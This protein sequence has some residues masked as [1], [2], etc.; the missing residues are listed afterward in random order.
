MAWPSVRCTCRSEHAVAWCSTLTVTAAAAAA[1][2]AVAACVTVPWA[3]LVPVQCLQLFHAGLVQVLCV[4]AYIAFNDQTMLSSSCHCHVGVPLQARQLSMKAS[5]AE[6]N[7]T[8]ADILV[9]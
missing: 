8:D 6:L 9:R 3:V 2:A 7:L 5:L 4:S 1:A